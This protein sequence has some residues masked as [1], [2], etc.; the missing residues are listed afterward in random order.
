MRPHRFGSE[1]K[2]GTGVKYIF[3]DFIYVRRDFIYVRRGVSIKNS[4][5]PS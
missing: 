1:G 2:L 4:I 3:L 5:F